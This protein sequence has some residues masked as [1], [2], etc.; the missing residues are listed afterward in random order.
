MKAISLPVLPPTLLKA[1]PTPFAAPDIAG[2]AEDVTRD[3][4]CEAFEVTEE[5]VSF[6]LEVAFEAT[7]DVDEA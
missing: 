5:V 1:F 6:A 7:S 3:R 4:P 2:P